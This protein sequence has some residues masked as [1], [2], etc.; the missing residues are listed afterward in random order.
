MPDLAQIMK[1]MAD[2]VFVLVV[3]EFLVAL[4]VWIH[5]LARKTKSRRFWF[6]VTLITFFILLSALWN[7]HLGA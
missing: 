2:P 7:P 6:I 4:G 5:S 1:K 3:V